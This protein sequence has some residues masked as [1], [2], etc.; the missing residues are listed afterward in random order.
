MQVT[1][2]REQRCLKAEKVLTPVRVHKLLLTLT[3]I[4]TLYPPA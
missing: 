3:I 2:A 4:Q 1:L